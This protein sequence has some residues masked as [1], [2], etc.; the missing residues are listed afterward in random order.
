MGAK[1]SECREERLRIEFGL[2]EIAKRFGIVVVSEEFFKSDQRMRLRF[3][4]R[5]TN[6][7][8]KTVEGCH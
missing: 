6:A 7:I 2:S 5:I 3:V 8:K 4:E 1:V